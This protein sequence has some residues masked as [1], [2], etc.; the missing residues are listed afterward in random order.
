MDINVMKRMNINIVNQKR[1]NQK[2]NIKVRV[3][4]NNLLYLNKDQEDNKKKNPK[5]Y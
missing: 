2:L 5:I 3:E 1:V 4:K